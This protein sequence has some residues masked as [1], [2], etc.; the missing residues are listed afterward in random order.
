MIPLTLKKS[1]ASKGSV[2]KVSLDR[3]RTREDMRWVRTRHSTLCADRKNF[4]TVAK[5]A[6][7]QVTANKSRQR[8]LVGSVTGKANGATRTPPL[9]PIM[10]W[11]DPPRL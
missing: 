7:P 4:V 9:I 3:R 2:S 10:G 5:G 6:I 11:R 1:R 8:R